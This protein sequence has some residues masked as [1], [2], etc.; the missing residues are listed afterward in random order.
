MTKRSV[1]YWPKDG[2]GSATHWP[3]SK[4]WRVTTPEAQTETPSQGAPNTAV[5][6]TK[7]P[8]AHV[9]VKN[10]DLTPTNL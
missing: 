10:G 4:R 3:G 6:D 5:S 8:N 9:A 1:Q 7:P 2:N